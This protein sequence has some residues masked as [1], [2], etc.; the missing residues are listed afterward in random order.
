MDLTQKHC[1]PCEEGTPPLSNE[2]EDKFKAQVP[3]WSLLRDGEHK[4]RRQFKFKDFMAAIDFVNKVAKIA[5]EEGHHPDFY[6]FYNKV[7]LDLYT[8][9]AG[10]LHENDFIIANKVDKLLS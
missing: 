9:A 1:I 10:G 3:N 6:I 5:D 2:E 7:Q 4:I 8:H